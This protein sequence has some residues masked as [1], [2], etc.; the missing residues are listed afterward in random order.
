MASTLL[1]GHSRSTLHRLL[2]L[3]TGHMQLMVVSLAEEILSSWTGLFTQEEDT[4]QTPEEGSTNMLLWIHMNDVWSDSQ[5]TRG[6]NR[7]SRKMA[8]LRLRLMN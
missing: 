3:K 2:Q 7:G 6:Q 8:E 5:R 1:A 4:S